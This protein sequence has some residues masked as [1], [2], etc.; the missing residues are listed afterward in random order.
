MR[1]SSSSSNSI[2]RGVIV[3]V[4]H[5]AV[6][7]I[8][9]AFAAWAVVFGQAGGSPRDGNTSKSKIKANRGQISSTN[10]NRQMGG[11]GD[12]HLLASK[13]AIACFTATATS[14]RSSST[15]GFAPHWLRS[16]RPGCNRLRGEFVPRIRFQI[17]SPSLSENYRRSKTVLLAPPHL[18]VLRAGRRWR[19]HA[20][21]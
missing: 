2:L 13:A 7:R 11:T 14:I 17:F 20:S 6:R 5:T 9:P 21:D 15:S 19:F 3:A 1:Y 12:R 4:P 16:E 10:F 8:S 18:S